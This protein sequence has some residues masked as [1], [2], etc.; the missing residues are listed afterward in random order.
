[1]T[2]EKSKKT[3]ETKAVFSR[4]QLMQSRQFAGRQDALLALLAADQTYTVKEAERL[5]GN[6]MKGRV[7]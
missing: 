5:I 3:V 2:A 6:Y 7:R 1:M 4:E